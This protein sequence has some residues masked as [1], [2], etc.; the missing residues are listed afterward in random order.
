MGEKTGDLPDLLSLL[1]SFELRANRYAES[2]RLRAENTEQLEKLRAGSHLTQA[3]GDRLIGLS[4]E[5][6][7]F[8]LGLVQERISQGT[9]ITDEI[10][11]DIER[12]GTDFAA[13]QTLQ[14]KRQEAE[15]LTTQYASDIAELRKKK[16][17]TQPESHAFYHIRLHPDDFPQEAAPGTRPVAEYIRDCMEKLGFAATSLKV[18]MFQAERVAGALASGTDRDWGSNTHHVD[19]IE[20]QLM[21]V[22]GIHSARDVTYVS[23]LERWSGPGKVSSRLTDAAIVF[24]SD[25][26]FKIGME[27]NGFSTFITSP[28]DAALAVFSPQGR[29]LE[30]IL[31]EMP[32]RPDPGTAPAPG[33]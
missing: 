31:A 13:G 18:R 19:N 1:D 30:D 10:F 2:R 9:T 33:K 4:A 25:R 22:F 23:D 26:L 11:S 5:R 16:Q 15:T 3:Q 21:Q 8:E 17:E 20:P 32:E 27:S 14:R 6:C 7:G 12:Q 28:H 24:R 29:P